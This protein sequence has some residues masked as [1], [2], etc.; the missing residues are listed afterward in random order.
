M[1]NIVAFITPKKELYEESRDRLK[2]IL[3]PTTEEP[4]CLR[5]ELYESKAT[6]QL[7]LVE[8]W[9]DQAALD[10]HYAQPYIAEVFYFY[11]NALEKEPEIHKLDP[12]KV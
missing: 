9:T 12:I 6:G 5:F 8:T 4:G 2:S 10:E 1:L 7:V 3:L 11:Q